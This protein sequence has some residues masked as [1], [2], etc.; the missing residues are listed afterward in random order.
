MPPKN[1]LSLRQTIFCRKYLENGGNATQA[2]IEAG[3]SKD[4]AGSI[5]SENLTKP[6]ITDYINKLQA[7]AIERS[8]I[9]IDRVLVELAKIAFSDI[10]DIMSWDESGMKLLPS[11]MIGP[12]H[13]AAIESIKQSKYGWEVKLH[14]KVSALEKLLDWLKAGNEKDDGLKEA[15][16]EAL[17]SLTNLRRKKRNN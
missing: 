17:K 9:T 2:A 5:G 4:S 10:T 13:S 6:E 7:Q 14:N 11:S 16:T 15:M 1:D 3:Y 12:Y 8:N